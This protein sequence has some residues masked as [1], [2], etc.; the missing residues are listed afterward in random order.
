MASAAPTVPSSSGESEASGE[1]QA[2]AGLAQEAESAG[3]S[4]GPLIAVSRDAAT[5]P[6]RDPSHPPPASPPRR[7]L[8]RKLGFLL[9]LVIVLGL[10]GLGLRF[11]YDAFKERPLAVPVMA[12][13]E[14][15]FLF[16]I[17]LGMSL[18]TLAEELTALG[19]LDQ[20]YYFLALAYLRGDAG[21]VKAGE[22]EI[23]PGMTP[24]ALLDKL[25]K[26][27]VY[28][29]SL[30]LIEGW[31]LAQLL[32]ALAKD[33][34]LVGKLEGAT[35]QDLMATL[36][37]AGQHPEGRFFPD[38]Y[39]FTKGTSDLDILGRAAQAMDRVLAGEWRDRAPG[40]PLESPDQALVLA[41][42]IEK[43]TGQVSERPAIAGVFI[44]RLQ[45][46]MR[47]QT[48]P[49][50]IYG[51]GAAFDGDLHRA[52]LTRDTPYNTY[53]RYGLPPTPIALPGRAA[54]HATL[55][56]AAG[57]SLYFVAKGDGGHWFSATLEEHNQAVRRYQLGQAAEGGKP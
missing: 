52:D 23:S 21:R 4:L 33:D 15:P 31:T 36:G 55:H 40:L 32:A 47:L 20:P 39:R 1:A 45:L 34:R 30:T 51:L 8:F 35:P 18:R 42:I 3:D 50:V 17:P 2:D 56:P 29:R 57:D 38:T 43:E 5:G 53:T 16:E 12:G 48:D 6:E 13:P 11:H 54:I 49:T 10:A 25:V 44:R 46:G 28:Q 14:Q 27:Q 26:N 24:V 37:R 19:V 22:Y 9:L 41:S 7:R